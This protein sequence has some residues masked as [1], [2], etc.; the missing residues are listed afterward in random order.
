MFCAV[1]TK[2]GCRIPSLVFVLCSSHK[3]RLQNPIPGKRLWKEKLVKKKMSK[4]G[5]E[6]NVHAIY[7][8]G[9]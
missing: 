5:L 3:S 4:R 1:V 6:K 9:R 2:A 7:Q 8:S